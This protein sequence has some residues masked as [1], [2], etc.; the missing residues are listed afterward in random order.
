MAISSSKFHQMA[1]RVSQ[2]RETAKFKAAPVSFNSIMGYNDKVN[3]S[4]V[5]AKSVKSLQAAYENSLDALGSV[6][7]DVGDTGDLFGKKK[8]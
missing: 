5:T 7:R 2:T 4:S 1:R 8:G 3:K 6:M